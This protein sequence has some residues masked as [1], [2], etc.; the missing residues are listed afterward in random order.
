MASANKNIS[1]T[2]LL[3]PIT[4]MALTLFLFSLFQLSQIMRD[5]DSLNQ[6]VGRLDVPF[7]NAQKLNAQFSGLVVGT[8]KLAKEGNASAKDIV[9]RLKKIGVLPD[10][11]QKAP[12]APV[13]A[14]TEKAPPG[15]VK[16]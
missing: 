13:P 8:Q 15:P 6:A 14:A 10:Q 16:P 1:L 11:D 4:L 2:N 7:E 5:R 3:I 9:V 12:P